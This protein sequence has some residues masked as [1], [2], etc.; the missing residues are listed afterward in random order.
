[1]GGGGGG[2]QFGGMP[3]FAWMIFARIS[4]LQGLEWIDV[5]WSA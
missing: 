3:A 1:M 2:V 4:L 5:L